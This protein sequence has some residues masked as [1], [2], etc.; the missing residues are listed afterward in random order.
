VTA[1]IALPGFTDPVREAQATFR[2]VLAALSRPGAIHEAGAGLTPPAPLDPATAAVLLALI[3]AD[4]PLWLDPAL[5]AASAWLGFHAGARFAATPADAAFAC[6][7]GWLDLDALTPGTHDAPELGATLVLQLPSLSAGPIL[8]LSGPGIENAAP[9]FPAGLP[10]DFS[11]RW[12]ANHARFP[13]G[14]DLI[15]CAGTALAALPRSTA[16]GAG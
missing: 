12:A 4:A 13:L 1:A 2:A 14:I 6:A 10:A 3:D 5:G 8:M 11:A 7:A 9:F 16:V 15:L